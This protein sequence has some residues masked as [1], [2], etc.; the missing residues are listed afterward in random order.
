M[1]ALLQRV[2]EANVIVENKTIGAI[3][4][5]LLVFIGIEKGDTELLIPKLLDKILNYRIFEDKERKMNL[6]VQDI[7]GSVLLVP[8]FTLAA[9]TQKGCRPSFSSAATPVLGEALFTGMVKEAKSKFKNIQQ[10][11]FAADMKVSLVNDGP[12]TFWLQVK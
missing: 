2:S 6:S 11:E 1:I 12:A 7:R 8:Q 10:G 9:D 4:Q 5:G 3:E